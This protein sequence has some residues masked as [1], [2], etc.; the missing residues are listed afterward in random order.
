MRSE[1]YGYEVNLLTGTLSSSKTDHYLTYFFMKN[2]KSWDKDMTHLR[3][4]SVLASPSASRKS[5][6]PNGKTC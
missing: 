4:K 2:I 5:R 6:T 1:L 3:I